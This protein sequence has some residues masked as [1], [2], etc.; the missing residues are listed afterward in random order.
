MVEDKFRLL[1]AKFLAMKMDWERNL[2][3]VV[4]VEAILVNRRRRL[5]VKII[6]NFSL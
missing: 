3:V 2:A 4:A 6:A 1:V 5:K